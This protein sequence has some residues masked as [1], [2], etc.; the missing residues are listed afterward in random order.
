MF[1]EQENDRG[2][3]KKT[4]TATAVGNGMNSKTYFNFYSLPQTEFTTKC[5]IVSISDAIL[6]ENRI[7]CVNVRFI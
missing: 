5:D 2:G 6:G 1:V 3:Q 7:L 4:L